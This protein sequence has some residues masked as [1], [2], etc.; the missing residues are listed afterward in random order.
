M[1][2]IFF[3]VFKL[4]LGYVHATPM[5]MWYPREGRGA[6]LL[7]LRGSVFL[8][9]LLLTQFYKFISSGSACLA[10]HGAWDTVP[11]T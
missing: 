1:K 4:E 3:L 8:C 7:G 6:Y 9:S 11:P 2:I 5:V 10:L